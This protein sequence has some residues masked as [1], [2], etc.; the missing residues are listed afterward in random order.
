MLC[1]LTP[2]GVGAGKE[3]TAGQ[4]AHILETITPA[5]TV[6][7]ARWELA[8]ELTEDLR[9]VDARIRETRKKTAAA[10]R[11]AA[12]CLTGLFGWAR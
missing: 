8:A 11:A 6:E 7:A 9:A 4:A 2:G 10:V 5:D 12:T 1:E 3:I